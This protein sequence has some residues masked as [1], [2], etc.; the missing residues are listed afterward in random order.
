[1]AALEVFMKRY[2]TLDGGTTSTKINVVS[3]G[4][5]IDTVKVAS[6]GE[7]DAYFATV[8]R[9]IAE[10]LAR[11]AL[12]E[13]DICRIIA[14]GTMA[15][16]ELGL[17]PCDHLFTPVGIE[18]LKGGAVEVV[19]P[20]ISTIPFVIVRGVKT[21]CKAILDADMMRGEE[22]EIMGL[23]TSPDEDCAF[24][25]MGSHTKIVRVS[26]GKIVDI[27]TMLTGE[28]IEAIAKSTIL[29]HSFTVGKCSLDYRYLKKGYEY[30][31]ERGESEAYFKVRVLKNIFGVTDSEA[32]SFFLGVALSG[33]V[34]HIKRL[35]VG[36]VIVGGNR[37]LKEAVCALLEAFTEAEVVCLTDEEVDASVPLGL[38][39]IFE[40]EK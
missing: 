5:I 37:Y 23:L 1:M 15:T 40:F 13:A 35:D 2:V 6:L 12:S 25:L 28:M 27:V 30:S 9:A 14:S 17:Y 7:R 10:L 38:V 8:R 29:K 26:E 39:K 4:E 21:A 22:A 34:R 18:E 3:G 33:E 32:Y 19:I 11:C 20:E 36:R 31:A 16:S 24:M